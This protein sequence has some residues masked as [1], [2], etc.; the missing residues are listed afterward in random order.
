MERSPGTEF[1]TKGQG[2]LL[3]AVKREWIRRGQRHRRLMPVQSCPL[4][5]WSADAHANVPVTWPPPSPLRLS[6]SV[7]AMCPSRVRPS[8]PCFIPP[9]YPPTHQPTSS[10]PAAVPAPVGLRGRLVGSPFGSVSGLRTLTIMTG[11]SQPFSQERWPRRLR[12]LVLG[13]IFSLN[14]DFD[15]QAA[16]KETLVPSCR[17]AKWM[18]FPTVARPRSPNLKLQPQATQTPTA[19]RLLCAPG[20]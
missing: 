4:S 3:E 11:P 6:S 20:R 12:R 13:R 17:Q 14:R 18:P 16:P 15:S 8:P 2:R 19:H 10:P 9:T 5:C 1:S 7:A